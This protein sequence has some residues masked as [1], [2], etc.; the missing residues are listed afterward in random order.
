MVG[1]KRRQ[2]KADIIAGN[3]AQRATGFDPANDELS[4]RVRSV[5]PL[6][7]HVAGTHGGPLLFRCMSA[8]IVLF[9]LISQ[10]KLSAVDDAVQYTT[11]LY[12][13]KVHNVGLSIYG[14]VPH[15][16]VFR[17]VFEMINNAA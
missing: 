9:F 7:A 3:I 15:L 11:M 1:S 12:Y 14:I 17:H 16:G 6:E 2:N 13:V 10:D 8:F 5:L 4:L